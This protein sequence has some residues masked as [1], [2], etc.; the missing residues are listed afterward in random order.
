MPV[1]DQPRAV[2]YAGGMALLRSLFWVALFVF[3]TFFFEYGSRDF[4]PGF[5]KEYQRI[6]TYVIAQTSKAPPPAEKKPLR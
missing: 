5:K 6:K 1:V 4:V 3:F 2:R